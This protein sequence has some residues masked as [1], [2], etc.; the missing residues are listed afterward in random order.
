[1]ALSTKMHALFIKT[2][3]AF[4]MACKI[5]IIKMKMSNFFS[6]NWFFVVVV[7]LLVNCHTVKIWY[8]IRWIAI[9]AVFI[10]KL[11]VQSNR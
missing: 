11:N 10:G 2:F 7:E 9:E 8:L 1:M 5:S 4:A 3:I 6:L